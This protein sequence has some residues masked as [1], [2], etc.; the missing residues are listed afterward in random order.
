D[1]EAPMMDAA[2]L[3]EIAKR[4]DSVRDVPT[5][6]D[7]AEVVRGIASRPQYVAWQDQL[8]RQE[9][10]DA[11]AR[12][13]QAEAA[14]RAEELRRRSVYLQMLGPVFDLPRLD[15]RGPESYIHIPG[16]PG[17]GPGSERL[18]PGSRGV[19]PRTRPAGP[20]LRRVVEK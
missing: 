16:D 17:C 11:R 3:A 4:L 10:A 14:A 19:W 15:Q 1:V 8:R 20:R 18:R 2:R 6:V 7:L 13:A 9:E 5:A 12:E